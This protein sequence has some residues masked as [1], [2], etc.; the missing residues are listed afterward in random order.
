MCGVAVGVA[1]VVLFVLYHC[2]LCG[3]VVLLLFVVCACCCVVLCWFVGVRR[4]VVAYCI[5]LFVIFGVVL[6]H[7][8]VW[9]VCMLCLLSLFCVVGVL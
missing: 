7:C 9:R 8:F 5:A 2:I 4:V 1:C 6:M 3:T